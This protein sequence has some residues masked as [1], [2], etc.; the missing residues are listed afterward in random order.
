MLDERGQHLQ[1]GRV[2]QPVRVVEDEE[3][4]FG[5]PREPAEELRHDVPER[6]IRGPEALEHRRGDRL[7]AVEGGGDIGEQH[8]R[9]VGAVVDGHPRDAAREARRQLREDRRLAIAGGRHDR[10]DPGVA[11]GAQAL[12]DPGAV[13]PDGARRH[14]EV[15]VQQR[16]PRPRGRRSGAVSVAERDGPRCN[17]RHRLLTP[18]ATFGRPLRRSLSSARVEAVA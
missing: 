10:D 11:R 8:D 15:R 14:T 9:V 1:R 12:E 3:D 6:D 16:R 4:R 5:C 17:D 18:A 2:M 13:D 7:D